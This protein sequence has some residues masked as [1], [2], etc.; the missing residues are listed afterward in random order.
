[1]RVVI[2]LLGETPS[3]V[4]VPRDF[5]SNIRHKA[6]PEVVPA[7]YQPYY[8][9]MYYAV[10]WHLKPRKI[11]EI[12]NRFGYSAIAMSLGCNDT[13]KQFHGIDLE[14]YAN[15][16]GGSSQR[17]FA[18]NWISVHGHDQKLNIKIQD[19]H[20]TT[21]Q[22][23]AECDL[24]HVDGDHTEEGAYQDIM[25]VWEESL[26]PGGTIIV[27]DL[28]DKRVM[29]AFDRAFHRLK[30]KVSKCFLPTRHLMGVLIANR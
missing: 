20:D 8:Y 2:S 22:F 18:E 11:L 15:P 25:R 13:L 26:A 27:D 30:G 24:V 7:L 16:F 12:G 28:D 3:A 19:S 5:L 1:M 9:E 17:I 23:P 10:A 4:D 29:D 6:D 21:T 14:C